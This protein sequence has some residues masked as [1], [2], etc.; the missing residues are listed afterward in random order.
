MDAEIEFQVIAFGL[1]W[2]VG[3]VL[4]YA[5]WRASSNWSSERQALVRSLVLALT[6]TP[7]LLVGHGILPAPVI[8][9]FILTPGAWLWLGVFPIFL[10]WLVLFIILTVAQAVRARLKGKQRQ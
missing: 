2:V 3:G 8:C 4:C 10:A 9:V 5:F 7:S 6:F 1:A